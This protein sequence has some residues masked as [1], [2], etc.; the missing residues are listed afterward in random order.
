MHSVK[1]RL[2]SKVKCCEATGSHSD[3]SSVFIDVQLKE[4][5]FLHGRTECVCLC[6]FVIFSLLPSLFSLR[7]ATTWRQMKGIELAW[8]RHPH[9]IKPMTNAET[10]TGRVILSGD[11]KTW[12]IPLAK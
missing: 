6:L 2:L 5:M 1:K 8:L 3:I 12:H 7:Y 11:G 9:H 4:Q 10:L